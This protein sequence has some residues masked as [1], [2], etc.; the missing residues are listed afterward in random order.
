MREVAYGIFKMARN[1]LENKSFLILTLIIYK[2]IQFQSVSTYD[3]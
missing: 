1:H 3:K 2:Q